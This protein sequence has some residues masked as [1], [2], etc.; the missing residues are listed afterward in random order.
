MKPTTDRTQGVG[1]GT[2]TCHEHTAPRSDWLPLLLLAGMV[3][4]LA[5]ACG[6]A[7]PTGPPTA[8]VVSLTEIPTPTTTPTITDTPAPTDTP[9][10]TNTPPPPTDTSTPRPTSTPLPP[11]RTST[12]TRTSTPRP[13]TSTSTPTA[14]STP[15]PPEESVVL[16][17]AI[18]PLLG[19]EIA[20]AGTGIIY[21][22]TGLILTAGHVVDGASIIK[23]QLPGRD[24]AVS[25]RLE[26]IEPCRDL[27]IVRIVDGGPHFPATF[28][29][30]ANVRP[31]DEVRVM[32]FPGD[33][34][35]V[36]DLSVVRGIVN[37]I[38]GEGVVITGLTYPDLIE[39]DA[40]VEPGNSGG[41]LVAWEGTDKG[42]VIGVVLLQGRGE[43]EGVGYAIPVEEYAG[44]IGQLVQ[45]HREH[46][47]GTLM[48]PVDF[49]ALLVPDLELTWDVSGMLV[50]G[51]Y[52]DS[53]ADEVG[54]QSGDVLVEMKGLETTSMD[55]VCD[56]LTT[57]PSG[58]PVSIAVWREGTILEGKLFSDATL[59]PSTARR[60]SPTPGP[61]KA[62]PPPAKVDLE[63]NLR[64]YEQ[65]GRPVGR[66]NP[67]SLFDNSSAV[68]KFNVDI[69]VINNSDE[70][71]TEWYPTFYANTGRELTTCWYRY[72]D[73]FPTV[74]TGQSVMVTFASFTDLGEYVS[75]V[76]VTI[77]GEGY[78]R[79]FSPE[80]ALVACP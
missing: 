29:S 26:G 74:P 12:P 39:T 48:I 68:R 16:I 9:R 22:A 73:T 13:P 64:G 37:R 42:K 53:P 34:E 54:M 58:E 18:R 10:P 59:E 21:D 46:W 25:A 19:E 32:G 15:V 66:P 43:K 70:L 30:S 65:W 67:C 40:A 51:V 57:N 33:A 52:P 14:T 27:A 35:S 50:F 28:G 49:L 60:P 72:G 80:G 17:K 79:C 4:L 41:P 31:G 7:M 63:L 23:V 24:Q 1:P 47:L 36:S 3:L 56:V 11:A 55:K 6:G 44:T 78:R 5:V 77:S 71:I 76:R 45:G 69:T 62:P 20:V 8:E 2:H 38:G 61:R 75:E